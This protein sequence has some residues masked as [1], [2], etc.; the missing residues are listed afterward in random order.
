M[1]EIYKMI[2]T[3]E[4]GGKV[5][6]LATTRPTDANLV[7][8]AGE[9]LIAGATIEAVQLDDTDHGCAPLFGWR[10]AKSGEVVGAQV[11]P[12]DARLNELERGQR[13]TQ[14]ALD[15][16]LGLLQTAPRPAPS[17]LVNPEDEVLTA[18]RDNRRSARVGTTPEMNPDEDPRSNSMGVVGVNPVSGIFVPGV[19]KDGKGILVPQAPSVVG[20]SLRKLFR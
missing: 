4:D 16:I 11:D 9:Y 1:R 3:I 12:Y 8:A 15:Q 18:P 5:E 14:R 2:V 19:D 10:T 6:W 20:D 7:E 17:T 13:N